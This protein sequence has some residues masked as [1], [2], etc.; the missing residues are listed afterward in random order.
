MMTRQSDNATAGQSTINDQ[1][2]CVMSAGTRALS[3][4]GT[5]VF[6][7]TTT[8]D[9]YRTAAKPVGMD[10]QRTTSTSRCVVD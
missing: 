1:Q 9:T 6:S 5:F 10:A 8:T 2:L 3:L 7:D 4:S